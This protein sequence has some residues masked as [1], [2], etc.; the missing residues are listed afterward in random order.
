[1]GWYGSP[2][3][4]P[5]ND[6]ELARL[7]MQQFILGWG[8]KPPLMLRHKASKG[9]LYAKMETTKEDGT[10]VRWI[11]VVLYNWDDGELM[12]KTM[13][14]SVGPA[15]YDVPLSWLKDVPVHNDYDREWREQI[16]ERA[17]RR[18]AAGKLKAGDLVRFDVSYGNTDLWEYTGI[19]GVFTSSTTRVT[20]RLRNWRKHFLRVE[21]KDGKEL[22]H[23]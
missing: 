16:K 18:K 19:K 1:M 8:D 5:A 12:L 22:G 4:K 15:Y 9:V 20:G 2:C 23:A 7:A 21:P 13:D 17:E 11:A 3:S 10:K 6:R 14:N